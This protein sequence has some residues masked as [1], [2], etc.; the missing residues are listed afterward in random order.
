MVVCWGGLG[1]LGCLGCCCV[2]TWVV[3]IIFGVGVVVVAVAI[4]LYMHPV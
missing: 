2:E 1:C 3:G 4:L